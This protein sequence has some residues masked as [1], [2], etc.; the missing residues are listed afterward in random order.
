M[1][2]RRVT[3][4]S[5]ALT[6]IASLGLTL[7]T[8]PAAVADDTR[9]VHVLT[10]NDF[11]G[12][13][14]TDITVRW[15]AT[16]E[17]EALKDPANTIV[18]SGGDNIGASE[19][20]SFIQD[21]EPTI[22]LLND[23]VAAG[24]G[25]QT[26]V[27]GN[28]EFDRGLAD[29]QD[30]VIGGHQADGTPAAV[31]ADWTYIAAN[32]VDKTSGQPVLA[33][34]NIQTLADGLRI[35]IVGA[36]TQ[37][38]PALVSPSGVATVDFTDPVAA[39]NHYADLIKAQDLADIVIADYHEGA[40]TAASLDAALAA[41]AVFAHLVND[42]NANVD[43]IITAHTHLAYGWNGLDD[44]DPAGLDSHPGRPVIQ[45]GSY[46]ANVGVLDLTVDTA[47]NQVVAGTAHNVPAMAA[48][49]A[50]SAEEAAML[51]IGNIATIKQHVDQAVAQ[52]AALGDR[53]IGQVTADITT[54]HANG[55]WVN[56]VYT[57]DQGTRDDRTNESALATLVADALLLTANASDVVG[58]ADIG[59]I[60]AGG[61]LRAELLYGDDGLISYAEANA[62]L[63]FVNNLW[64]ISLTGA[65]FKT[66]LEEQWQTTAAGDR[67]ARPFLATGLSSNVTYTVDTDLP[68]A[69]PCT[70]EL[71][72]AWDDA[73][74]HVTQVFVDGVP[75]VAD[76]TYKIMTI[77]F[78]TSG[79]DNYRVMT[80]GADAKDTGLV[81]RDAWIAALMSLS[82]VAQP[83]G[84]ATKTIAPD[85]AR[86][87]VV[88]T[89]L[90]P[91]T[92]P[93]AAVRATAGDQ[94]QATYSRLN[95]T[96]LGAVAN[97]SMTTYLKPAS[98]IGDD[99][100]A[101]LATTTVTA[102][103]DAA[104]CAA[105]GVPADLNPASTGCARLNVT[106]PAD[107]AAGDYILTSVITPSGTQVRLAVQVTASGGTVSPTPDP[108][109]PTS[110]ADQP[111][112][113]P[114]N[115]G[116]LPQSG[117]PVTGSMVRLAW[118]LTLAGL[119]L[120]LMAAQRHR[121]GAAR[122]SV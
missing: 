50:G 11:H 29:L 112:A 1:V 85:F 69:T 99:L 75:L 24:I 32:V 48:P 62:V 108:S 36:V 94:I 18:V 63:P 77:S 104:G 89:G 25:F 54:A 60:N 121:R 122:H 14:N 82:G 93:M 111:S 98:A 17:Q 6:L 40:A 70:L 80:Q 86:S 84:A 119:A 55:L 31:K 49:A 35:A 115:S 106:I 45:T 117:A 44:Q 109:A 34:Y 16:L 33:P 78:L 91:A 22:Q 26:A 100:G 38:T 9:T 27:V 120:V 19:F 73:G 8:A 13:I 12:R 71:A 46:G 114:S 21:D 72:C 59:I 87:S 90:S 4:V 103:D 47:T 23:F 105:L 56:N 113:G 42:T 28:H 81:D 102:P 118:I 39:V 61:G 10:F 96:S 74:S 3:L 116:N 43:A 107:T 5:L 110:G 97:T 79:G 66:F 30:R 64:S 67:P 76:Q 53:T 41:T 68:Q 37:E 58:G 52:G 65:Q 57:K 88:V 95:L 2:R 83:D 101:A 7:W 51:A 92:A 20:A 15:A